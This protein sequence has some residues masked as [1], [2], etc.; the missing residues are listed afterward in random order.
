MPSMQ[1]KNFTFTSGTTVTTFG[2]MG[3]FTKTDAV[4]LQPL[5]TDDVGLVFIKAYNTS[6]SVTLPTTATGAPIWLQGSNNGVDWANITSFNLGPASSTVVANFS[7]PETGARPTTLS[8]SEYV[9]ALG[10]VQLMPYM[11]LSWAGS[12]LTSNSNT[13]IS[14]YIGEA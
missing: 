5:G 7:N 6:S 3:T 2:L 12:T 4:Q 11:R 1:S 9:S 14:G 13:G 10:I 8:T